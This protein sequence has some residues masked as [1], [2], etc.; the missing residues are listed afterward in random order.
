MSIRRLTCPCGHSWAHLSNEPVPADVRLI[1]P[2]CAMNT[3]ADSGEVVRP[4][5]SSGTIV[6]PPDR[7]EPPAEPPAPLV[8]PGSIISGFEII[9][10]INRGGM[11]IIYK[12]RQP[13]MHRLVALKVIPPAKMDHP[14]TRSRFMRE[15]RAAGRVNHIS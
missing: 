11:G 1:C 12:A 2:V 15:V 7:P 13:G 5:P 8:G 9:E 4:A 6:T 3:E 10:E 14:G